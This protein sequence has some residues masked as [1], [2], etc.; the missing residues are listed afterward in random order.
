MRTACTHACSMDTVMDLH[1]DVRVHSTG[2]QLA[3]VVC[4]PMPV[5]LPGVCPC[6][7]RRPRRAIVRRL[8]LLRSLMDSLNQHLAEVRRQPPCHPLRAIPIPC[9]CTHAHAH[10]RTCKSHA[11]IAHAR[12]P[13]HVDSMVVAC[14]LP[15][16][17][18]HGLSMSSHAEPSM[19]NPAPLLMPMPT[20]MHMRTPTPMSR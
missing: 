15:R 1:T 6:S 8:H 13:N 16:R 5:S 9:P 10:A 7:C 18:F 14:Q 4:A 2:V 20:P 19:P 12:C 11:H 17:A 3:S